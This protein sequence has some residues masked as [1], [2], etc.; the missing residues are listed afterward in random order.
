[1]R[2]RGDVFTAY[3]ST[4]IPNIEDYTVLPETTHRLKTALQP[5]RPLF[6]LAVVRKLVKRGAKP[7][8]TADELAQTFMHVWGEVEDDQGRRAVARLH[9]PEAGV[10]WTTRAALAA[11]R[12]VLTGNAPP[13]FQTPLWPMAQISYWNVATLLRVLHA[14]TSIVSNPW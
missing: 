9:G 5:L 3:Y 1:M 13:R 11:V 12:K 2:C 8:A 10:I 14:K 4:G 6:K 7:G